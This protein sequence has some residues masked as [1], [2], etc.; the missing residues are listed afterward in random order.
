MSGNVS[1]CFSHAADATPLQAGWSLFW[2]VVGYAMGE[3][4]WFS[5]TLL[6]VLASLALLF[7]V[8][9]VCCGRQWARHRCCCCRCPRRCCKPCRTWDTLDQMLDYYNLHEE[10]RS[11]MGETDAFEGEIELDD[12]SSDEKH[13]AQEDSKLDPSNGGGD[14]AKHGQSARPPPLGSWQRVQEDGFDRNPASV[15]G[16]WTPRTLDRKKAEAQAAG[17][18]LVEGHV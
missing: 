18:T 8:I 16:Q 14:G 17:H 13:A 7:F 5:V 15:I 2:G 11:A 10:Y 1:V 6:L 3:G 4:L 12:Y 9:G